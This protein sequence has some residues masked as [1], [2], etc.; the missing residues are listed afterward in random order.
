LYTVQANK[1][2]SCIH[3]GLIRSHTH[4]VT[5][6][7][8]CVQLNIFNT[9]LYK[10]M[11]L[12]TWRKWYFRCIY[13]VFNKYGIYNTLVCSRGCVS[14]YIYMYLY[15]YIPIY[16]K[17]MFYIYNIWSSAVMISWLIKEFFM[18]LIFLWLMILVFYFK[19][20]IFDQQNKDFS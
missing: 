4:C 1:C 19:P 20:L 9:K 5:G 3:T 2:K 15:I 13:T 10:N 6:L 11:N 17:H 12:V 8:K 14:T 18:E 7:F 16:I